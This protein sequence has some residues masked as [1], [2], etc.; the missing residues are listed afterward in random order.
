MLALPP[1]AP[2]IRHRFSTR[3]GDH[4]MRFSTCDYSVHP[5]AIGRRI[6]VTADLDFVVVTC[7]ARRSP[8]TDGACARIA[9]S[10][11]STTPVPGAR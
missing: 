6:E 2:A 7:A 9:R 3:L 10:R 4:Y 8:A 11:R 1:A 5:K